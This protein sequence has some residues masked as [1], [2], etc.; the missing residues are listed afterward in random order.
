MEPSLKRA[1][2]EGEMSADNGQHGD[3]VG[4]SIGLQSED[5]HGDDA[6]KRQE[7]ICQSK[8]EMANG[9]RTCCTGLD[10]RKTRMDR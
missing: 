6:Q 1:R 8:E 7:A 9:L 4:A 3:D 5:N 10:M 2:S